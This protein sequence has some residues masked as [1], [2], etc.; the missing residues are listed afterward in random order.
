[1]PDPQR[2]QR[3][4]HRVHDGGKSAHIAGLAGALGADGVELGGDRIVVEIEAA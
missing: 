2:R 4:H 1:M 3:I